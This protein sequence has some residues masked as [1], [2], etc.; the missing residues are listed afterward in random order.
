MTEK[1][2]MVTSPEN[3]AP[4]ASSTLLG[5]LASALHRSSIIV[6]GTCP[7]DHWSKN[8]DQWIAGGATCCVV[9]VT[10]TESARDTMT[11]LADL[12]KLLRDNGDRLVLATTTEEI[13]Q[14]KVDEKLAVVIQFQGTHP[15]E[16][17]SNLVELYGR[18]GVRI[19][20]LTYN[21]RSAVG[22][23]CEEPGNAGLSEFGHKIVGE[24]NRLGIAVDLAHT[25]ERTS[26]D[27]I[28]TS[29]SPCIVSHSNCRSVHESKRNLSDKL[30][31]AV[32]EKG[33]V[34]GLNG[35]PAFVNPKDAPTLDHL[36]DHMIH[37]DSM[38]GSGHVGLGLDYY[39]CGAD[40]YEQFLS[41]GLWHPDSY[42]PPPWN[43]P[44]GIEDPSTLHRLTDRLVERGYTD[45]EIRG[46]LGENWMRIFDK[47]WSKT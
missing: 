15:I 3:P 13:R 33:G 4:P 7:G 41:S 26:L 31:R 17:D 30:I 39:Q 35:F 16:Y 25:G 10:S 2:N 44:A 23:G 38:A 27:A 43:F 32:T 5:N 19:V 6:D 24:L 46:V 1:T 22:D 20:Q 42:P 18:L 47:I 9:T 21:Q 45:D 28:E 40:K 12:F 34:I 29:T 11:A 14:A 37:I 8:F 36:I